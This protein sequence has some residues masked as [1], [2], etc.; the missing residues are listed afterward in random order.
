[1]KIRFENIEKTLESSRMTG[2]ALKISTTKM[3]AIECYSD[4]TVES[5]LKIMNKVWG[6]PHTSVFEYIN[7]DILIEDCSML[8][9]LF[10][11]EFR[12]ISTTIKSRRYVDFRSQ[13]FYIPAIECRKNKS[14]NE[15]HDLN[16]KC[17]EY[18]EERFDIYSKLVDSGEKPE[19]ARYILPLSLNSNIILHI[20]ATEMKRMAIDAISS[21]VTEISEFGIE[22]LSLSE[23]IFPGL[24][25]RDILDTEI[26]N[27]LNFKNVLKKIPEQFKTFDENKTEPYKCVVSE[28]SGVSDAVSKKLGFKIIDYEEM[29]H[30]KELM[31]NRK[32][33]VME[34]FSDSGS[35][36]NDIHL[37]FSA[38]THLLRHR[39][40]SVIVPYYSSIPDMKTSHV[41]ECNDAYSEAIEKENIFLKFLKDNDVKNSSII[42]FMSCGRVIPVAQYSNYRQLMHMS[43]LRSC[44]RAQKEI[45][46][47]IN[48]MVDNSLAKNKEFEGFFG[49]S[50]TKSGVCK[51]GKFSCKK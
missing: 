39:I 44:S 26:K 15:L 2:A 40:Q 13:G 46:I 3:K 11:I 35:F 25:S 23:E 43:E 22:L 21:D 36:Y 5:S 27:S 51:E 6:T 28:F 9:E 4:S 33:K 10:I 49:P 41:M 31:M 14:K 48:K 47:I 1:M 38:L 37:S 20:N 32:D 45:R 18:L 8:L 12:K 42:Y 16:E 30:I 24:F 34:F 7:F 17:K 29:E 19:D 50:C